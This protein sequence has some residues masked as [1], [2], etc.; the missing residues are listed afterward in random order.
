MRWLELSL[1]VAGEAAE[2]IAALL[3]DCGHQGVAIEQNDILPDAWDDGAAPPPASL[4]LRAWFPD[5]PRS[6]ALRARIESALGH[7]SLLL[8][9]PQPQ[10]RLVDDQDW[11]EAWKAH[12]RPLRVGRHLLIRPHWI[13]REPAAAELEIVLDPGMAFGTGTHPSTQLCLRALEDHVRPGHRVLDLGCGSGILAIAAA[14]L[15]AAAVLALDNDPVAVT[16]ARQNIALNSAA[17]HVCARHGSLDSLREPLQRFDLIVVN[18]LAPVIAR[19]CEQG[20]ATLLRPGAC[21]IFSGLIA[22][23]APAVEAALRRAGLPPAAR[24]Q[25]EDWVALVAHSPRP[26]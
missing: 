2:A 11:A 19:F 15:G 4:T 6:D 18:I 9:L 16:A 22:D 24:L 3:A 14:A 20:L 13:P 12:Y 8:P 10:W 5:N 25:Q 7:M 1:C 21:G 26:A 17:A 23:Q